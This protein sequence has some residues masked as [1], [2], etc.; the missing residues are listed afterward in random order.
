MDDIV[1]ESGL[2]KGSLYWYFD[3]KD[4]L[5]MSAITSA[6]SEVGDS[7]FGTLDPQNSATER[8][9]SLGQGMASF[10]KEAAGFLGLFAEFWAQTERR[11]EAVQLWAGM[12]TEY[13]HAIASIINDGIASGEF[14]PVDAT[15]LTWSMMAAYDGIAF[16]LMMIPDLDADAVGAAFV[17]TLL[18]GLR[19]DK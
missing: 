5:F 15:H 17:D 14:R 1:A 8:L 13:T 19:A 7:A 16:Y 4:D 3:S 9:R 12:L 10:C 6:I 18:N 11:D 2:S